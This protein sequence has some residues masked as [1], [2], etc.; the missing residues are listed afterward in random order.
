MSI[1][2]RGRMGGTGQGLGGYCVCLNCGHREPH[3]AGKPCMFRLC[4]QCKSLM[5]RER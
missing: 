5:I 4:P 1:F 2:Q 3:V